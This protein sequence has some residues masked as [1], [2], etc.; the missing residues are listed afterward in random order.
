M[1]RLEPNLMRDSP[2]TPAQAAVFGLLVA[3]FVA[4]S[5]ECIRTSPPLVDEYAHIP[6]GIHHW[7]VGRYYLYREN[8]PVVRSLAA[9]PG[10][11]SGAAVDYKR[12]GEGYRSE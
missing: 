6:A 3:C 10:L 12:A 9:L 4:L 2:F 5:V 7:L 1:R 8:P 11:L